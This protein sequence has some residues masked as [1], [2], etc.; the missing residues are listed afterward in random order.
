M[1]DGVRLAVDVY[2]PSESGGTAPAKKVPTIVIFTPYYRRFALRS[3]APPSSEPVGR[4]DRKVVLNGRNPGTI[5]KEGNRG[6]HA[7]K[8]VSDS[9]YVKS[10]WQD[11]LHGSPSYSTTS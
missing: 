5:G 3:D 10:P 11:Q 9:E 7:V 1:R 8:V 6:R 4:L 2:L